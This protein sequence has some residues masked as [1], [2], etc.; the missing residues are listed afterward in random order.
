MLNLTLY[1]GTGAFATH[2]ILMTVTID[3]VPS[4]PSFRPPVADLDTFAI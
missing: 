2:L 1:C 3:A 4:Q